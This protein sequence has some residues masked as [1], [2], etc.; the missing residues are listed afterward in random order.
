MY[1]GELVHACNLSGDR[2]VQEDHEFNSQ[3]Y[4]IQKI[5]GQPRIQGDPGSTETRK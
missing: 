1:L 2:E 3:P 4:A 5:Q